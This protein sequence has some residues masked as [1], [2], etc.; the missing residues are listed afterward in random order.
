M[1]RIKL[2]NRRRAPSF[3]IKDEYGKIILRVQVGFYPDG[4]PGEVFFDGPRYGTFSQ[5]LMGGCAAVAISLAWQNGCNVID[6][7]RAFNESPLLAKAYYGILETL[8][9]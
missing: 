3:D 1:V 8:E 9:L 5:E 6:T 4:R 2:P 7:C